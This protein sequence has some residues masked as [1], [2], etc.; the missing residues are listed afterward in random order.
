[1]SLLGKLFGT[2]KAQRAQ[3]QAI[4]QQKAI[5]DRQAN[6]SD[7]QWGRY[8]NI[9]GPIED[10]MVAN[11]RDY[12]SLENR[13]RAAR[14]VAGDIRSNYAHLRE[15]LRATPGLNLGG[16]KFANTLA[17]LD[18]NEAAQSAAAQTAVRRDTATQGS[19]MESDA[20]SLGKGLPSGSSSALG[21]AALSASQAANAAGRQLA[22]GNQQ[23]GNTFRAIGDFVGGLFPTPQVRA[24]LPDIGNLAGVSYVPVVG[25]GFAPAI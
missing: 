20:L 1:M 9:F 7:E 13:E 23:I 2:D 17:K 6:I 22:A 19:S 11:A 4:A 10:Q 21:S 3:Q 24:N 8:Q 16:S 14:E 15:R 12:G 25:G 18:L 5:E